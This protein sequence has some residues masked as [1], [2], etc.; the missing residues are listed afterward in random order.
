LRTTDVL[1]NPS[2]FDLTAPVS[3]DGL[4]QGE[5]ITTKLASNAYKKYTKKWEVD[6]T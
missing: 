4:G 2:A 5:I 1:A 3:F 6:E